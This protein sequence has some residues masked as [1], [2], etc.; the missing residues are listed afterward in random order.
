M[1]GRDRSKK[2]PALTIAF[3]LLAVLTASGGCVEERAEPPQRQRW[4]DLGAF[5][6]SLYTNRSTDVVEI[7]SCTDLETLA[8]NNSVVVLVGVETNLTAEERSV[9]DSYLA[10]G[11][12]LL[13]AQD[14]DYCNRF[15]QSFGVR[16]TGHRVLGHD[17]DKNTSFVK[18]SADVDG[19]R[20][21]LLGNDPTGLNVSAAAVA[22]SNR[23]SSIERLVETGV[24][25]FF[26]DLDD[27]GVIE[28]EDAIGPFSICV[29]IDTVA[30]GGEVILMGDTAFFIDDLW[31]R[32][33]NR[34]F[35]EALF[36]RLLPQRGTVY[37][38]LSKQRS[39]YSGH[40]LYGD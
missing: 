12:S 8:A 4:S 10:R 21:D 31:D 35:V 9:L 27:D 16:F 2:T 32:Y 30:D 38:D 6:A 26:M 14:E 15:A 25:D 17:F 33:E 22:G 29:A 18:L 7:A 5:H 34:R 19:A 37:L 3:L 13:L 40:I 11:G 36:A 39:G 20:Y 1:T 23:T 28:L 24:E